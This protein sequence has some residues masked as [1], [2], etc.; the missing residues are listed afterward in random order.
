M[1]ED[2]E[3]NLNEVIKLM[4]KVNSYSAKTFEKSM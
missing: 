2:F 4:L 1:G 3:N